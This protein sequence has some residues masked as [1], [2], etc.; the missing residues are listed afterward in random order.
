[1]SVGW[2]GVPQGLGF[3][4]EAAPSSE[5]WLGTLL[6]CCSPLGSPE[7]WACHPS[8]VAALRAHRGALHSVPGSPPAA[9]TWR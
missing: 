4:P 3:T 6:R 9:L 5:L 1:M 2:R 8:I 7:L